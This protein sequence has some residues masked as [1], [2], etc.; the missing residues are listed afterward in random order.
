MI[1]YCNGVQGFM[2]Y[3]LSNPRNISG[4]GIRY[5]CQRYKNKKFLD[6]DV[7]TILLLQKKS[8]IE[9]YLCLYTYKK[10]Y[11]PHN[12][13][14]EKMVGSTFSSSNMHEVEMRQVMIKLLNGRKTFYLEE[15]G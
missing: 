4:E 9:K 5:P 12:T 2:N 1:N 7:V 10:P 3:V 15:I 14:I 8:F 6:V 11:V 13:M